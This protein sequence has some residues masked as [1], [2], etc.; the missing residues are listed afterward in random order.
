MTSTN[1]SK[2]SYTRLS[3]IE[4]DTDADAL[5]FLRYPVGLNRYYVSNL[6]NTGS[7]S[8]P[9]EESHHALRV[10]R[11]AVGGVC[12]A[13]DGRGNEA[14]CRI[15]EVTN[16][17]VAIAI[18]SHHFKPNELPGHIVLAVAMPKG[19]R[20]KAVIEKA[21]EL[22]V[23]EIVPLICQRSVSLPNA[24]ASEKW[25]RTVIEACKQCERNRLMEIG[26]PRT[27]ESMIHVDHSAQSD[28]SSKSLRMFA[29][30]HASEAKASQPS[31]SLFDR[32]VITYSKILIAIGPEGGFT[33]DE[34]QLAIDAD[35][36]QLD[37]GPRI[38]R[39]ETAVCAASIYASLRVA[40]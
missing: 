24:S 20:Q 28:P 13:F 15:I 2:K 32:V 30:P 33:N 35:W 26:Q 19:D 25:M 1:F 34:V 36:R 29:H 27:F 8:L 18:E 37:L 9:P 11:E 21:V 6:P 17:H 40:E 4:E 16:R 3:S 22:G 10:R 5:P 39:V 12:I 7:V 31:T 38:L 23:H 14:I